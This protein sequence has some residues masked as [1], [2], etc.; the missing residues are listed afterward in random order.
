MT[1]AELIEQ[2]ATRAQLPRREAARALD[3]TL[4]L[5]TEALSD[6]EEV[7]LA[8]FGKFHVGDR[9]A[10]RGVNPRTGEAI[11]IGATRVPRFSAGSGLKKAV[12]G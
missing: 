3:D 11:V 8:G 1:K 6:G 10:R 12:R 2:L 5:I 4:A 7:A 9:T